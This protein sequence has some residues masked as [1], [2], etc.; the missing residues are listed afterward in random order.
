MPKIGVGIRIKPED[1]EE[2]K[3]FEFSVPQGVVEVSAAGTKN[4]FTYDKIFDASTSQAQV[5]ETCGTPMIS[6]VLDGFNGTLFAY[7][8][9]GAGIL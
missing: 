2:L 4:E 5:F 8:Q 9:T 3:G 7:G 1:G 6:C